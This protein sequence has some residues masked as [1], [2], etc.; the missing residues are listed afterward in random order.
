MENS[1]AG[2]ELAKLLKNI[3]GKIIKQNKSI[4]RIQYLCQLLTTVKI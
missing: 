1:K 2:L 4:V 3:R